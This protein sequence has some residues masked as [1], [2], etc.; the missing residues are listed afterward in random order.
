M[1]VFLQTVNFTPLIYGSVM[2]IGLLIMWMK[3]IQFRLLSLAIDVVV[4]TLVFKL[5]GGSMSGGFS[6]MIAA[7]LAGLI[8]PRLLSR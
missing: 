2:F 5:H 6:A 8:F 4:F 3:L 1:N 7:L